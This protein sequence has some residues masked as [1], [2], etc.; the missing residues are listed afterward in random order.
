MRIIAGAWRGKSLVAPTG[1]ATRPTAQRLR[2]AV[3]DMIMHA[4]WGG[5]SLL[6]GALVLD[7][8]AGTGALG[9]A[10][11]SRGAAQAVFIEND[12]RALQALRTNI[13]ACKAASR[14]RLI[15]ADVLR[16][17][18][19]NRQHIV[20][21]D[22]PYGAGLVPLAMH[23]LRAAGWIA[24]GTVIIAETGRLEDE[25]DGARLAQKVHGAAQMNVWREP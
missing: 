4:P 2:Q 1:Q 3:F 16:T 25:Q 7:A 5:R 14:A 21:L 10:A 8:I 15:A 6:E 12:A 22:P 20:F 17:I 19:G 11:L 13:A 18:G 24:S 23:A 9:L